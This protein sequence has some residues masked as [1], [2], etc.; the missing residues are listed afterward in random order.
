[1]Y[2]Q[3]MLYEAEFHKVIYKAT[4]NEMLCETLQL[5]QIIVIRFWMYMTSGGQGLSSHFEDQKKLLDAIK[6]KDLNLAQKIV[7][8]H[9]SNTSNLLISYEDK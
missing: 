6:N 3:L 1:M 7:E 2:K 5:L 9:T 4:G 8:Q